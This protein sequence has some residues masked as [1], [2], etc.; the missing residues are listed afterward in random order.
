MT[1]QLAPAMDAALASKVANTIRFLS[2]DGVQA[3]N[4]GHPGLPMGCAEIATVLLS[5]VM[6]IDP[7]DDKWINRDRFVLSAG[8]GSMLLYSMLYL[9][10]YIELDELKNFRQLGS[11]TA[12]HPEHGETPGVDM[13]AGPLG[14]GFSSA[15]GMAIAERM[16]AD[17]YNTPK[18]DVMDHYT[19][20]LMGDGCMMEGVTQEAASLAGHL[21]LGR[22]IAIYDD[23]EISIE[24][25]TDLSF[26]EDVPA[27]FKAMGWDIHDV[28]DG[29]DMEAIASA[30]EAAQKIWDKPSL[31]IAHTRIGKGSPAM[32]GTHDVHGA[33]LGEEEL[34]AAK[35]ACGLPDE[36]FHVPE[37]VIAWAKD[38]R[39]TWRGV[40]AK[41][42]KMYEAYAK[43]HR[44]IAKEFERVIKG[45][46][47]KQWKHATPEFP[48][49]EA[50]ATRISGGK[51]MNAFGE[52][53]PELVGGSADLAPSTKTEIKTGQYP[54][55]IAPGNFLGRNIH[56]G[57][58]EHGMGG[59]VNGMALHGGLIP[60]G[61][62][63]M[64]F[65]DYMRPALRLSA[66]MRKRTIWVYTHDSIFVGEDGPTHQPVETLAAM[67]AIPHLDVFR[68]CDANE[69]AYAWQYAIARTDGPTALALSRQNL[70]TLDRERMAPAKETLKGAYI[71]DD[72][73]DKPAE[74]LLMAS[75]SEV[76]LALEVAGIL[77]EAGRFVRVVSVPSLDVFNRQSEGYR[78]R[79]LPKRL[80]KRC[81]LEAG[82]IQG[83]EGVLGEN[84]VFIGMD[85]FG[86]SGP[87]GK[88]AEKFGFTA[89]KVLDKL[90]EADF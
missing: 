1:A 12:G 10:G 11:K 72:E 69:T 82:I 43:A 66:L 7:N 36:M 6:R 50:M 27:R 32:E 18:Y 57:V 2:A 31:I 56:F 81:V 26:T 87:A 61:S 13:T 83:W 34:S 47:P 39:E 45:E 22:L 28:A 51:V 44:T 58:R 63:F 53:I 85:D 24:G 33:P 71:L 15:V 38:Q 3:A 29:H 40:R 37:E 65:H 76:H 80:K 55:F 86:A 20:L 54:D 77:R 73:A 25:S 46:L 35:K 59:I 5:R 88:V 49:G 89:E 16:L 74:I 42:D 14:A 48:A 21:K 23:N 9:A 78:K 52:A 62:T 67:R 4:S 70:T 90:A 17:A 41:W 75:G 30:I 64:V 68:P 60:F 8:H 79:I 84:G 19:Y